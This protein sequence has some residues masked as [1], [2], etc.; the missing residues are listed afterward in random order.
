MKEF[1]LL[2]PKNYLWI[3]LVTAILVVL[4]IQLPL[5]LNPNT[6]AEDLR[7]MPWVHQYQEPDLFPMVQFDYAAVEN[8]QIGSWTFVNETSAPGYSLLFQLVSYIIPPALFSKLLA[9]PL[10]L[11]SVYYLFRIGEKISSRKTALALSFV[12]IVLISASHSEISVLYGLHR[13]FAVPLTFALIYYLM[14][15]HYR[16]ALLT[17]F[18]T[19]VIYL[20][21]FPVALITFVLCLTTIREGEKWQIK[22]NWRVFAEL[23][24]VVLL[25][26]I[27]ISPTFL[28]LVDNAAEGIDSA[29]SE[30]E[31]LL[32]DPLFQAGGRRPFW[33]V[34]PIIGRLG[35]TTSAQDGLIL[36]FLFIFALLVLIVRRSQITKMPPVLMKLLYAS[37]IG[38]T[39]AWLAILITSSLLLY[40]PS[41]HSRLGLF[42]F[43]LVFVAI[44]IQ[45]TLRIV[46]RWLF[47]NQKRLIWYLLPLA[48]I[49]VG[50]AFFLP[51]SGETKVDFRGPVMSIVLIG[52]TV[53]LFI[54]VYFLRR[55]QEDDTNP[56]A[57]QSTVLPGR[58]TLGIMAGVGIILSLFFVRVITAGEFYTPSSESLLLYDYVEMLPKDVLL[59]GSPCVLD[60]IP[61]YS[62]RSV[63]F[64]CKRYPEEDAPLIL[65]S[66]RSNY[67][68]DGEQIY[69]FCRDYG[70]THLAIDQD[71]LQLDF[72]NE[73]DYFFEPYNSIL[74]PELTGRTDFALNN[75]P[76]DKKLFQI[77]SVFVIPCDSFLT[78]L[79]G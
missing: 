47:R 19:G 14:E 48:A 9:F 54:L 5:I 31:H 23:V 11:T 78:D 17:L 26:I 75:V 42:I 55:R 73:G 27:A 51:D 24:F 32:N 61:F 77:D 36:I 16:R 3:A 68:S 58:L 10:M 33:T 12:F 66:M 40:L 18:L 67:A 63:L 53:L 65:D 25:V 46:A 62:K 29:N 1:K 37:L 50:F 15:S 79:Q 70:V 49:A 7:S 59:A 8:F 30:N 22:I 45:E 72:V 52:L 71:T 20:P 2:N 34:F 6:I 35:L 39:L 13:S 21:S 60:N 4:W 74:A 43:L 57:R 38:Y 64:S 76:E 41:R 44:N 69:S 28:L 56:I